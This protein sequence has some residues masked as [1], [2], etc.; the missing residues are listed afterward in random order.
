MNNVNQNNYNLDQ[1]NQVLNEIISE[2][3]YDIPK[4]NKRI[5]E[6]VCL[7]TIK[8]ISDENLLDEYKKSPSVIKCIDELKSSIKNHAN[9]SDE[10]INKIVLDYIHNL[11]KS[12]VKASI[13]GNKFNQIVKKYIEDFELDSNVFDVKFETI[14]PEYVT[15]EK[16][17]WYI[18]NKNTKKIIIGMNQVDLW[19]GGHQ[20]NRGDKY[21]NY[22][23]TNN[24]KLLCVVCNNIQFRKNSKNKSIEY[25]K[26]G[27]KNNTL[28]YI[29]NIRK[30]VN[31]F[32][33]INQIDE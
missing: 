26:K 21:I 20:I 30:I 13:R 25:F 15:A 19:K 4:I 10:T 17:D 3:T 7:D 1:M 28:C 6:E 12:S 23:N 2:E 8:M 31:D 32:F 14:H 18:Y 16:P 33:E 11:I 27:F 9:L 29:K 22:M 5:K 24:M